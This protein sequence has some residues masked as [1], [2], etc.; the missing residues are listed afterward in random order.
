MDRIRGK[1]ARFTPSATDNSCS[2]EDALVEA[3]YTVYYEGAASG[4]SAANL[5]SGV[6]AR[7]VF[8]DVTSSVCSNGIDVNFKTSVKFLPRDTAPAIVIPANTAPVV[9]MFKSGNPSLANNQYL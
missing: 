1:K 6:K 4:G 5:V 9:P 2:C 8:A 3:H 7:L